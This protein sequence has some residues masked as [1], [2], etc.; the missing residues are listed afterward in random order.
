M[1]IAA[2]VVII[3]ALTVSAVAEG[4]SVRISDIELRSCATWLANPSSE[5]EGGGWIIGFWAGTNYGAALAGQ[6]RNVGVSTD[7]FDIIGEVK[8]RCLNN[9]AN[10]LM[11]EAVGLYL[12]F[13]RAGK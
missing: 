13:E 4:F 12:E 7:V 8:R 1:R 9:P 2:S 6:G 3:A 5:T 11:R 10:T